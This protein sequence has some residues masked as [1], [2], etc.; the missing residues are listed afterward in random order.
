MDVR[1]AL[2]ITVLSIFGA[3][4]LT[5][6]LLGVLPDAAVV[7]LG[8]ESAKSEVVAAFQAEHGLRPYSQVLVDLT[9]F[10]LG[11]TLDGV[12]VTQELGRALMP[13]FPRVLLGGVLIVT[14]SIITALF[15]PARSGMLDR[16]ASFLAFLPPYVMP[17]I[18]VLGILV[19]QKTLGVQVSDALIPLVAVATIAIIPAALAVA[20]TASIMRRNLQSDFARTLTAVGARP[21]YCRIRLLNNV[22]AEIAPSLEKMFTG[23]VAA[24]LFAEPVLGLSG[25]GTTTV[26][27]VKRSDPDLLLGVTLILAISVSVFRLFAVLARRHYGLRL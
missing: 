24:L 11:I 27:A 20:Q 16:L 4:A 21:L 2:F 7:S 6:S 8:L 3:H 14:L 26:R 18:G 10:Q 19:I 9:R 13:S 1:T 22:A 5:Y 12:P 17:F 25:F 23:M 15:V